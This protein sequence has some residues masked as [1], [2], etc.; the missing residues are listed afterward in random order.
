MGSNLYDKIV[1]QRGSLESLVAR[2]PGF[3]GY[4]DKQARRHADRM[5][6]EF[7]VSQLDQHIDHFK[8]VQKGILDRKGLTGMGRVREV[9]TKLQTY[10]DMLNAA[11]PGYDGMWAQ[12]KIESEDLARIYAFDEAQI[13]YIDKIAAAVDAVEETLNNDGD[14]QQSLS[15]LY[16]T[17]VESMEAF[18]LRDDVLTN[19]AQ[20]L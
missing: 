5:L 19:L 16:D 13:V 2:I 12:M 20:S 1:S 7:L 18:R 14:L 15:A 3:R 4:Q 9:Q 10:R 11:A 17:V 6:R 8:R